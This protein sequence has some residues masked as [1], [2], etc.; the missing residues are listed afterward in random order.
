[1]AACIDVSFA[2][3]VSTSM[4]IACPSSMPAQN[5]LAKDRI[6]SLGTRSRLASSL[7]LGVLCCRSVWQRKAVRVQGCS[8]TGHYFRPC[9]SRTP[10]H[11][12]WHP[13]CLSSAMGDMLDR[14]EIIAAL[15][16]KNDTA[17][18]VYHHSIAN[19][20]ERSCLLG[21][22]RDQVLH[23]DLPGRRRRLPHRHPHT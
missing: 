2:S 12:I 4:P 6:G 11:S 15:R 3:A 13:Q 16:T 5:A 10:T 22:P 9:R 23:V 1:M 19:H 14:M 20:H 18:N 21:T 7:C 8:P 17:L